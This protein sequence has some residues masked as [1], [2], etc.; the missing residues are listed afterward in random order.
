MN[1]NL[2]TYVLLFRPV[3]VIAMN[4]F[5]FVPILIQSHD[6]GFSF[7][8]TLPFIVMLSG[9]IALNDCCDYE[10]DR[11]SKPHRP[12]VKGCVDVRHAMI[13]A[14]GMIVLSML[15]GVMVYRDTLLRMGCFLIVT[16]V[17]AAYN[18]KHP[19]VAMLKTVITAAMTV[20]TLSFV[21]TFTTFGRVQQFFLGA[22]FFFI[23]GR[24]MLMDIRDIEGD[25]YN[26]YKTIVVRW[27]VR[28]VARLSFASFL[29]SA[30]FTVAMVL[31]LS[32]WIKLFLTLLILCFE[33]FCYIR[34][35]WVNK[36]DHQNKYIL[37]LWVP[38]MFMLIVQLV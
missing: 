22:A 24:E 36:P 31:C 33:F 13:A 11:I 21:Y 6:V 10:K 37:L 1:S 12:L 17:L 2:R 15:L 34:C 28:C 30:I 4:L 18:L 27:G 8:Q 3:S 32:S 9:E 16:T 35:I 25:N 19:L 14:I 20:L 29:I 7:M 26:G 38:I 23:L 5:L